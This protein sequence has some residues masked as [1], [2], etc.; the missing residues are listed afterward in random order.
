MVHEWLSAWVLLLLPL[1]P[2]CIWWKNRCRPRLRFSSF[3]LLEQDTTFRSLRRLLSWLPDSMLGLGMVLA[4]IALARPVL[5][6][7]E[8]VIK[9]EGI[10][11]IMALDVSGSMRSMDFQKDGKD[12]SRLDVARSVMARFVQG[13][14]HD[15]IGLLLFGEEAFNLVPPTLDHRALVE[16]LRQVE[17]GMAGKRST[18]L[19]DA[20]AVAARRFIHVDAPGKIVILLTDGRSNSGTLSPQQAARAAGALGVR[21]YTIGVGAPRRDDPAGVAAPA[22]GELDE[23]TLREIAELT[24]GQYFRARN[25][26]TLE[27]V[28]RTIDQIETTETEV[29]VYQ[30]RDERYQPWLLAALLFSMASLLL[31]STILRRLP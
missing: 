1:V 10:D 23:S 2:L 18:A 13:R 24:G 26:D 19:G 29:K 4:V 15:R 25:T 28:Y 30:Q 22:R 11:I 16:F 12:V 8:T 6:Q 5:T 3:E 20:L 27:R 9:S 7:Q 31:D 17:I 14:F 21:V